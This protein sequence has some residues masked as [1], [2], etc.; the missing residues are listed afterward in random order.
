MSDATSRV[1]IGMDPHQRSATVEVMTADETILGQGRFGTDRDG[2]AEMGRYAGQ[3]RDRVW[4]IEGCAGQLF[5][6]VIS[7]TRQ[8]TV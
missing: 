3:W 4:V 7:R 8:T 6:Q 1:V 5:G 2:Y